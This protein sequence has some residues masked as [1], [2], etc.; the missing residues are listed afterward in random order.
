M[1]VLVYR[2][3]PRSAAPHPSKALHDRRSYFLLG[4]SHPGSGEHTYPP[5]HMY[6]PRNR[7]L[8]TYV[9]VFP[10]FRQG[11]GSWMA[12]SHTTRSRPTVKAA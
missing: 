9:S 4:E 5:M 10:Q 7:T 8:T 3:L 2:K 6:M 11:R 12:A 1:L